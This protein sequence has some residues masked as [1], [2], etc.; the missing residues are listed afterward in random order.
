LIGVEA[1]TISGNTQ[2]TTPLTDVSGAT[3]GHKIGNF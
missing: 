2:N 1:Q 3:V